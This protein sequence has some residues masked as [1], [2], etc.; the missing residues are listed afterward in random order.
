[1][2]K[3]PQEKSISKKNL[4]IT[5]GTFDIKEIY[6]KIK[7]KVGDMRYLFVEKAQ[8]TKFTKY[9][10]EVKLDFYLDKE[11]D[12]FGKCGITINLEFESVNKTKNGLD[13]GNCIIS[14]E[15]KQTLDY[16]NRWGKTPFSR[17]LFS[18]YTLIKKEDFKIKYTIPI[19]KDVQELNEYIKGLFGEYGPD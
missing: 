7:S 8:E 4:V 14:I 3:F 2:A 5:A 12:F 17:F 9:G 11:F 16:K 15:G 18:L 13:K 10:Q 19:I 6:K 1:M